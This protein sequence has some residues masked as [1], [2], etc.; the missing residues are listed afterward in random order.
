MKNLKYITM[1]CLALLA[2]SL[3]ACNEDDEYFDKDAQNSAITIKK[4]YLE[5]IESSVPDREVTFARLGQT[6]RIEGSGLYGTKKVFINGY[7]T[8]FNRA[9]VSDNNLIVQVNSKTPVVEAEEEVRNKIRLVKD[10]AETTYDFIIRSSAPS[11]T[12]V[13]STMPSVGEKITVYGD[14]LHE[15][16]KVTLPG[17][18]EVTEGIENDEE[19][20]EWF[21]FTMPDGVTEYGS[22]FSEGANGK[23]ASPAYFND[24][25]CYIIDFDGNGG[26]G[27]WGQ[28]YSTDDY[29]DDPLNSGRGK[30]AMLIP[31]SRLNEGGVAPGARTL[32]WATAGSDNPTND[33]N[34]M[35]EFIPAN[36]QASQIALQFDV[37]VPEL[38]GGTGQLEISLQ[39]NLSNYGYGS[40]ETTFTTNIAYPTAT[41]WV[42]WLVDGKNVPYT[43]GERWVTVTIPLTKFGKYSDEGGDHPFQEVIDDRNAASNANFI[44]LLCNPDLKYSEDVIFEASNIDLKI[45]VDNFR[46]VPNEKIKISDFPEEEDAE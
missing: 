1:S 10:G 14:N 6:L 37:Y 15:T 26:L 22:I 45:Y 46:I 21:S 9:L 23:A 31:Q 5:D 4:I 36:T 29:V 35:T 38:W 8:Y 18:V 40:T 41:V 27:S 28:T 17:G 30:V 34:R 13:S 16:V 20:G 11:I 43:T 39:N 24:G 7:D 3:T 12:S 19:S 33:W 2:V 25:R 42:P 44:F 32:L